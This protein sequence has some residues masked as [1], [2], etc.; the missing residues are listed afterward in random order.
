M[1]PGFHFVER[2]RNKLFNSHLKNIPSSI[3]VFNYRYNKYLDLDVGI[4]DDAIKW[5]KR[6]LDRNLPTRI[7]HGTQDDTVDIAESR[8]FSKAHP[9]VQLQELDSDHSLISHIDWIVEDCLVFFREQRF[10]TF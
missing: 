9:W 3:P 6:S 1:C 7:V 10:L 8:D 5:E 2:W 4:F